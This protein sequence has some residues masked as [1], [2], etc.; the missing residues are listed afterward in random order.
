MVLTTKQ[1][2]KLKDM[3]IIETRIS[4]SKDGKYLLHRTITTTIRPVAYYE[5]VLADNV[6][7]EEETLMTDEDLRKF[8]EAEA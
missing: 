6:K 2:M 4:R 5:A 7:V 8:L 3:P 1:E